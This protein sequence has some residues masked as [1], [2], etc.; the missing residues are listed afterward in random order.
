MCG[1]CKEWTMKTIALD[2]PQEAPICTDALF[3]Y[4]DTWHKEQY[5]RNAKHIEIT[6]DDDILDSELT[7]FREHFPWLA[8]SVTG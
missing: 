5:A 2:L 3:N 1:S 6:I 7:I 4:L 8:V